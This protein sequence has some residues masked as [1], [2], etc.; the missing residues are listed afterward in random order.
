MLRLNIRVGLQAVPE[1][2]ETAN[3][4]VDDSAKP[5]NEHH[6]HNADAEHHHPETGVGPVEPGRHTEHQEQQAS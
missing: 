1:A 6:N 3:A 4:F 5:A 2:V